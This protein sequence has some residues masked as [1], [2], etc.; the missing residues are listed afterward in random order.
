MEIFDSVGTSE[1]SACEHRAKAC[2]GSECCKASIDRCRVVEPGNFIEGCLPRGGQVCL[3]TWSTGGISFTSPLG[4]RSATASS[5]RL[6]IASRSHSDNNAQ[7]SDQRRQFIDQRYVHF[8]TFSVYRRRRLLDLD[9]PKRIVLGVL[10][11]QL[12]ALAARCVGFVIMPDHVHALLWL[13]DP[14]DLRRF[15]HGWKRMSSYSIR[16]WYKSDH[17]NR[18]FRSLDPGKR[19]WQP[20]SYCLNVYSQRKLEQKL[21]YMHHNPVTAGLAARATDWPWSSARW[22]V[23]H[24]SVGVKLHWIEG[25]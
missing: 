18:Y 4:D 25:A 2:F 11:H 13:D 5:A 23:E 21:D 10:N 3:Q 24:R 22:Y 20:K 17:A 15:L 1:S 19:F 9:Q 16:R 7:M 6:L 8:I 12:R 14:G